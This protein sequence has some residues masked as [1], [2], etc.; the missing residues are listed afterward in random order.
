ML[1]VL[2]LLLL[3]THYRKMLN[4]TFEACDQAQASLQ[5][6]K[7]F[8]HE[9]QHR[10][11]REE[12]NPDVDTVLKDTV[13]K[14]TAGL[15]D[16]LN[17]S[18]SLTALFEMIKTFNVWISRDEISTQDAEKILDTLKKMNS[19]LGVLDEDE[20][21]TLPPEILNKIEERQKARKDKNFEL[22]DRLRDELQKM[23]IIL[24][25]RKDGTVRWKRK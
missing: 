18:V 23:G 4:F 20:D 1:M 14:F 7:D 22:A 24:E 12:G 16:D 25:D 19:V 15:S 21:K 5:R 9:L 8:I 6:I 13:E 10:P 11:S 17:I 2:R 3:S